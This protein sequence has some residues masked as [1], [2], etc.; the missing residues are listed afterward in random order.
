MTDLVEYYSNLPRK[1]E[2]SRSDTLLLRFWQK[3]EKN[4]EGCWSWTATIDRGGYG[5]IG[6][7]TGLEYAHRLSWIIHNGPI[8]N[9]L[10]VLH[11]CDNPPCVR[12]DHLFL[13][14]HQDNQD[15]RLRKGRRIGRPPGARN[16]S[17]RE[18]CQC[19]E[20]LTDENLHLRKQIDRLMD[21]L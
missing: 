8:P 10:F 1:S 4:P 5:S 16:G 3:V 19:V 14:T 12:P 21:A 13:G 2:S 17:H 9:G 6:T 20:R 11:H 15:D 7:P 18:H